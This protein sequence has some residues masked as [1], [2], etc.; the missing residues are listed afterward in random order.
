MKKPHISTAII[1]SILALCLTAC[2]TTETSAWSDTGSGSSQT[3]TTTE[4]TTKSTTEV[5]TSATTEVTETSVETTVNSNFGTI[6]DINRVCSTQAK[7]ETDLEECVVI[8]DPDSDNPY[9][10]IYDYGSEYQAYVDACDWSTV[11]DAKY[12]KAAFPMLALQYHDNDALLL[13]H[14]Q[15]VGIHEGRQGSADFNVCAYLTN[16]SDEVYN[17]FGRN[18]A[19]H[20]IYYMLN[21]KTESAVDTVNAS[22]NQK[23]YLQMSCCNTIL[24]LTERDRVNEYRKDV[25]VTDVLI[26]S[27]LCSL[28]NYRAYLNSH[29]GYQ[30][31]DWAIDNDPLINNYLTLMGTTSTRYGEN[32]VTQKNKNVG[33][34]ALLYF[35]SPEHYEL[36]VSGDYN[37][38]GVSNLYYCSSNSRGSQFDVYAVDLK[39]PI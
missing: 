24:Q 33:N 13:K 35:K 6:E 5:T 11:F 25:N 8:T 9:D 34:Y 4:N 7:C 38:V 1:S 15:T 12:Y 29:D 30:A 39:T 36:M 21:I 26:N 17:T 20:Y 19:A 3:E 32:T 31:H 28:A 2:T 23:T 27:E 14:F 37:F 18:W 16:C 22:G 10:V